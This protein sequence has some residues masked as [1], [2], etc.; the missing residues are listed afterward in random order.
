M[1]RAGHAGGVGEVGAHA[2]RRAL[3]GGVGSHQQGADDQVTGWS[4]GV[5]DGDAGQVDVAGVRHGDGEGGIVPTEELL[6]RRCLADGDGGGDHVDNETVTAGPSIVVRNA[7]FDGK[8]PSLAVQMR[9]NDGPGPCIECDGSRLKRPVAPIDRGS[10]GVQ[11]TRVRIAGRRQRDRVTEILALI[12]ACVHD[13]SDVASQDERC[14]YAG[15]TEAVCYLQAHGEDTVIRESHRG[16]NGRAVVKLA[17]VVQVPCVGDRI[18]CEQV[19]VCRA[20][21]VQ[22]EW[23]ALFRHIWAACVRYRRP[24]HQVHGNAHG[25]DVRLVL[26][27][28]SFERK[29]IWAEIF[30]VGR[31]CQIWSIA[32]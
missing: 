29:E 8:L 24:V 19:G 11:D 4:E 13:W 2:G 17:I 27:V 16:G 15:L 31:V 32:A 22:Y 1:R 10:V 7:D 20:G 28:G 12:W 25:G 3:I 14:V 18:A 23:S 9:P 26:G 21:R 6:A 5:G 30:R